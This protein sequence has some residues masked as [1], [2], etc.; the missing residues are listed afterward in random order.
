MGLIRPYL[1]KGTD[2]KTISEKQ[3]TKIQTALHNGFRKVLGC[4]RLFE[5]LK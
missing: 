3:P 4:R 2:F 5:A 1:P